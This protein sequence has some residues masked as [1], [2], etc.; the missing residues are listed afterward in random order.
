MPSNPS[1]DN[2]LLAQ[3]REW[4]GARIPGLLACGIVA[5]AST[6][7]GEHYGGSAMLFALLLGM[8]VNF[9]SVDGPCIPGIEFAARTLLRFGVALLGLRITLAQ[10]TG[11]LGWHPLAI[12]VGGVVATIL[13]GIVG[14]RLLGFNRQ[15]GLLTGGAVGICGASA[16]L[17]IAAVLPPHE[18]KERALIFTVIGVS[19]LSTAAMVL[20]PIVAQMLHLSPR[21][22]GIFLGATIHDVAQVAGA[23]YGISPE[24]GDIATLVKLLRVAMLVPVIF[25]ASLVL[26]RQRAADSKKVPLLPGFVVAFV[27]FVAANSTGFVSASVGRFA[28]EVSRWCL[29]IAIA[30]IGI[31]T[32]LKDVATVGMRPIVLMVGETLFLMGL[33]M[34]LLIWFR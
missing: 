4:I 18:R 19:T 26:R 14:A 16:A 1:L 13:I 8:A 15:F 9:L 30:A 24:T 12:I 17:A 23:G 11:E 27:V 32:Q 29:V 5:L 31:K 33:V 25:V 28:G 2:S 22:I 21:D 7:L 6:F 3:R 10:V 34:G 20:Y